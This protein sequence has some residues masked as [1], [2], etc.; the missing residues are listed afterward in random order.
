MWPLTLSSPRKY[1]C[2]ERKIFLTL[3]KKIFA[4][5]KYFLTKS[6]ITDLVLLNYHKLQ[7]KFPFSLEVGVKG[8]WERCMWLKVHTSKELR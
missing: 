2:G 1:L 6:F 5:E 3:E 8:E 4:G 7:A